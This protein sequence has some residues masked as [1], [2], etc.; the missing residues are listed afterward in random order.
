MK[1]NKSQAKQLA[2]IS[3]IIVPLAILIPFFIRMKK[4]PKPL[5]LSRAPFSS[6]FLYQAKNPQLQILIGQEK[7]NLPTIELKSSPTNKISFTLNNLS[8]NLKKPTKENNKLIFSQVLPD[9]DLTYE[10]LPNGVKEEIILHQPTSTNTYTFDLNLYGTNPQ[11]LT[12]GFPAPVFFDNQNNYLFHFEKPFA[13]DANSQRTNNVSMQIVP[14]D[15]SYQII[16]AVDPT[17]LNDPARVYPIT[18]DPTVV[19]DETSEFA[20]GEFNRL[21]DTGSGSAPVL[22]TYYQ[23]LPADEHTVGLWHMNNAWT[24]S[25]GNSNNGTAN[26]GSTFS[27]IAK[28]GSYSGSFDGSDDEVNIVDSSSLDITSAITIESWIYADDNT[29]RNI[30]VKGTANFTYATNYDYAI[31]L[32]SG[33]AIAFK[34]SNGSSHILDCDGTKVIPISEW[35]HVVASWD[36]TTNTGGI[37]LY[38]DGVLDKTCT[39]SGTGLSTDDTIRLGGEGSGDDYSWDGLL[40]E[41]RISNTARTPEEIKASASRRPYSVYTSDVIDLTT[42]SAWT[43]LSWTEN[44]VNTGD[45]ETLFDDTSLVAQWNFNET[46]GTTADNAEG[47]AALDGTLNNFASTSSQDQAVGTGWTADNKKWGAGALTFDGSN[48]YVSVPDSEVFNFGTGD[49]TVDMWLNLDSVTVA[50]D[51][52]TMGNTTNAAALKIRSNEGLGFTAYDG[53]WNLLLDFT[54]G[55]NSGWDANTWYY[56]TLVRSGSS[57]KLYKNGINVASTTSSITMPD[58]SLFTIGT[59]YTGS[60]SSEYTDGAIDSMR[61]Y[62][63]R[64][65]SASEI[66]SNYNSSNIEFQTRVGRSSDPN[67]GTWEAWKPSTPETQIESFDS[68]ALTPTSTISGTT[69]TKYDNTIPSASD[70]SSTNGRIPLGTSGKGDDAHAYSTPSVI[71]DGDTY[72]MW[73]SG[74][75]GATVRIYYATSPDGLTWTKYDNTIP[76]NSDTSSTNG[77]IPLGTS[78]KGDDV[79]AY[80]PSVIKDGDTYK[81][82]YAGSDGSAYRLYYATSPDGLTWTKYDNTIPS[83]SDTTSTNGRIPLGTSGKGDDAHVYGHTIIK[84]GDTYKM[85]YGGHDGAT[86][87]IYYATS[88]DGL[89]WTKNDNTTASTCDSGGSCEGNG[90]IGLGT[91]G[92]GD[93]VQV[94]Y[95]TVI[96]DNGVYK[97]WYAGHDGNNIRL[98]MANSSDGLTWTKQDNTIPSNSDTS[99]TNGRIPLGTSG[100][101]DD[102]HVHTGL[103]IVLDDDYYLFWYVGYDGSAYRIYHANIPRISPLSPSS[104]TTTR[105]EGSGSNKL[106]TGSPKVDNYT[107]ALWHLDETNGDNAGVDVFDETTN[108][109]DG[110]FNGT[111]IATAVVDGISG[112]ARNF[113]GSDDYI[114][115]TNSASLSPTNTISI[116]AWIKISAISE[117]KYIIDRLETSDGYGLIV[118]SDGYARISINGGSVFVTDNVSLEDN[119]WHYVVGTYDKDAGGTT[120]VK[121]YVDGSLKNTGDYSTAIDYSPTPRCNVGRGNAANYFDGSIDE[122]KVS[123]IARTAEEIAEAYRAGRDHYIN[124]TISSTDLSDDTTL[125]FYVAADRPGTYLNATIGESAYANYQPDANTVG[126]WHMDE[127]TDNACN[128]GNDDVCD[129]SGN[130]NHGDVGGTTIVQGKIGKARN[131]DGS[132]DYVTLGSPASLDFGNNGPFTMSGWIKPTTLKDYGAFVSKNSTRA[133]PYSYMT[134]TMANGRL[135]AYTGSAWVDICPAGSV[136]NENWYHLTYAYNGTTIYGYVNGSYCGSGAFT[137]TDDTTDTVDIGSWYDPNTTYD[138]NGIIDEV[139]ISDIAR[140]ADEIRQA[141][142]VGLRTHP[143]T[144]DFAASLDSGNLITGSGDTSFTVDATA[145]GLEDKGSALYLG[146]KII[147]RETVDDTEYIA[148]GT[149]NAIT[150]STGVTTVTSW[151]AGSTFPTSGYT[152]NASVFKW[153]REYMDLSGPLSSHINATTN[154]TLRLTNG[155]EGR[156]IWLDDLNSSSGYATTDTGSTISSSTGYQYFQYRTILT[157]SDEAV[158]ANFTAVT[159]DYTSNS[160]PS[161]PSLD[162]PADTATGQILSPVLKTTTTDSDSDY[163]RYKIQLCTDLAMTENCQTFDQTSSQ[164]GWSSQNAGAET[165]YTSGTQGVYTIQTPLSF[166]TT[167][168]WRSY[169]IDPA[170][171]NTWSSTQGTPYSFTTLISQASTCVV[172][173]STDDSSLTVEWTDTSSTEAG[174]EVQRSVN[175]GAYSLLQDLPANSTSHADTTVSQG[176]TYQYKIASYNTGPVYSEWCYTPP[177]Q[178]LSLEE[179]TFTLDGLQLEGIR[180]D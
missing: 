168:Y 34:G 110:E 106:T 7:T 118:T 155:D 94:Y 67:D 140:T 48:D 157:S 46:S 81:M 15:S 73:Y 54:E 121:I 45:G 63:G 1:F 59:L 109:N 105:I 23:E 10:T 153:Q 33:G 86:V 116:S 143:I 9:T 113:N 127:G 99:S 78:G 76:S 177:S 95:P 154:L 108:N 104:D 68:L 130:G 55:S 57:W 47:T 26:G 92:K 20:T 19:H 111:N 16:L 137:Y 3:L 2:Y 158:S 132:N 41:I 62:K 119:N 39:A 141:Y 133:S 166:G 93:D 6:Q 178:A 27:S 52:W 70:T 51:M 12:K 80:M 90:K 148:Q 38:I 85:W 4:T 135:S 14:Q 75:D 180:L 96:K 112:K 88:P 66:L 72:K 167:Y 161:T 65:L 123:N 5:K 29:L 136:A 97:I 40:D 156:T 11:I 87:R 120:E 79:H 49:F 25:S 163:L 74:H 21:K 165:A 77:R 36:G 18:I 37:K 173:E 60:G 174:Y 164:T 43:D 142:E 149:V 44:G 126:L 58:Y 169:A 64:A 31:G 152:V 147:V 84:D 150:A 122:L 28:L 89:T 35:H 170:G 172:H 24:D 117:N 162:L 144:I 129:A 114:S 69:I 32:G 50:Q 124:K 134:V 176:N 98:Y 61:V 139:T 160:A 42:V 13:Y 125:P 101:G 171:S 131:F 103:A 82:W 8:P 151:D 100:K 145:Y 22:E 17:W 128:G 107:V 71:K 115:C 102:V 146:D 175:G 138:F 83:A 91:S 30:L 53:N 56:V 159:L 179:G